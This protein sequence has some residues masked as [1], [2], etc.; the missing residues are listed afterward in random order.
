MFPLVF[1]AL[2]LVTISVYWP[3]INSGLLSDDW[4]LSVPDRAVW[5]SL[6]GHWFGGTEGSFYRP[7]SR[8]ALWAQGRLFGYSGSGQ[9][10]VSLA[11]FIGT[12]LLVTLLVR[13]IRGDL[14]A[15]FA[16]GTLLFSPLATDSVSWVASQTDL[17]CGLFLAACA[18]VVLRPPEAITRRGVIASLVLAFLA[19]VSKDSASILGPLFGIYAVCF[20]G[21]YGWHA[22]R[23]HRGVWGMVVFQ[24]VLWMIYLGWRKWALG[25]VVPKDT[26]YTPE[27]GFIWH[28][29]LIV[30]N[31]MKYFLGQAIDWLEAGSDF[32]KYGPSMVWL[33]L[34]MALLAVIFLPRK[35]LV[36]LGLL[37]A[38]IV[39]WAPM[40]TS[41]VPFFYGS[42]VGNRRFLYLS[43]FL[44]VGLL[45]YNFF[46]PRGANRA[47][48][49]H[50]GWA[51]V[52]VVFWI[53]LCTQS[54]Q[55]NVDWMRAGML[56]DKMI[57]EIDEAY[58]TH[59]NKLVLVTS[60]LPD[61]IGSS[62][63]FR[64]G[65]PQMVSVY[66]GS[67]ITLQRQ[68]QLTMAS[69]KPDAVYY[70]VL[71][72][73]EN[74]PLIHP[75]AEINRV[76][77]NLAR[78]AASPP[79]P[80]PL[81]FNFATMTIPRYQTNLSRDVELQ[82][83]KDGALV[84]TCKGND[85][86]ISIEWPTDADPLAYKQAR[87]RFEYAEAKTPPSGTQPRT[88]TF[89]FFW[90]APGASMQN[91]PVVRT[92]VTL[93]PGI[94]EVVFPLQQEFRWMENQKLQYIRFDF[95]SQYRGVF[96]IIGMGLE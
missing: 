90:V 31:I 39:S 78:I 77:E 17:W 44:L 40:V 38:A 45:A 46:P 69:L 50:P 43:M 52:I 28:A 26:Q 24:L 74:A 92:K 64:S 81:F 2:C 22:F 14:A 76:K 86:W 34:L 79:T 19:Y 11:L 87:F 96:R 70:K 23:H 18:F 7:L 33:P 16:A 54:V 35:N 57:R 9:H 1:A 95:G 51:C 47:S 21:L 5:A 65:F 59:Q 13:R 71:M 94:Q 58:Q 85:P 82:G 6:K 53:H 83:I 56:R 61:S 49:F 42:L 37:L 80:V 88:D 72:E 73:S 63:V 48:A 89:E 84:L 15:L 66:W 27:F 30:H 8:I 25:V 62:Y 36:S 60:L 91:L 4:G 93:L 32:T 55:Q 41:N 10:L 12:I 67:N 3:A 29:A 68:E 20:I 75:M